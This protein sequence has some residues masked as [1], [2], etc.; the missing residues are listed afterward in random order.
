MSMVKCKSPERRNVSRRE[1]ER[2][3]SVLSV[4][5]RR[6]LWVMKCFCQ[7]AASAAV[8][9]WAAKGMDRQCRDVNIS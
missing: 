9:D 3:S 2:D 5:R 7:S 4:G 8:I 1:M 6:M